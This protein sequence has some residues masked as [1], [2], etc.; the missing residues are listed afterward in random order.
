MFF[1][2]DADVVGVA[3]A[4]EADD[5]DGTTAPDPVLAED[6]AAIDD[7]EADVDDGL[8]DADTGILDFDK[9]T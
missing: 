7:L 6:T 5:A 1:G 3:S 2:V 9:G 8:G 4:L